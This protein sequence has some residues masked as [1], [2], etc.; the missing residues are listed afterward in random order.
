[1]LATATAAIG[2]KI[3]SAAGAA[4]TAV[5]AFIPR[6]CS[7]GTRKFCVGFSDHTNCAD[8]P[9]NISDII[10]EAAIAQNLRPLEGIMAK[11]APT[12]IQGSVVF[13]LGFLAV[14]AVMFF[15]LV[16]RLFSIVG[17]FLRLGVCLLAVL[18]FIPFVIP[19]AILYPVQSEIQSFGSLMEVKKGDAIGKYMGA[20]VCAGVMMLLTIFV[21]IF[22]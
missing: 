5:E 10:P 4:E 22:M 6:N 16:F 3:Q 2:S 7:L 9:L 15:I 1:M 20:L 11:V 19:T 12:I 8:L 17:F 13:G 21:S 14:L 18:C